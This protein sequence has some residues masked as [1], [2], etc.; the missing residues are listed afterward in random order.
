[1][2]SAK[3]IALLPDAPTVAESGYAGFDFGSWNGIMVPAKTPKEVVARILA[4]T[5]A[6]LK[7]PTVNKRMLEMGYVIVGN[8]PDQFAAH[9]KAEIEGLGN[10]LRNLRGTA[11]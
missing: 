11:E 4:A 9:I 10:I 7:N 2:T 1:V 5:L 6:T 3:R 8:Q